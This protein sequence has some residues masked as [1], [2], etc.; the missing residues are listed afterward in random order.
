M[1]RR[2]GCASDSCSCQIQAGDGIAVGGAGSEKNPYVVSSTVAD[3]ETGF[4]V[5]YNNTDIIRGVHRIDFRGTAVS[6]VGG[7][8]EAV[9]TVTVP[10]PTTGAIIPTGAI[11]MFGTGNEPAGWLLCD[12][13]TVSIATYPNLFAAIGINFGGD[14]TSNFKLPLLVD[15]FPVGSGPTKPINST[16]GGS[17]SKAITAANLPPHNHTINHNHLSFNTGDSGSHDH[18][19]HSTDPT[20]GN[21]GSV[22]RGSSGGSN[23]KGPIQG[24]G[25][26]RHSIDVPTFSGNSGSGPGAAQLL[27]ITPPYQALAFMIKTLLPISD[28]LPRCF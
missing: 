9:V 13:R 25:S 11:W 6:V 4:D 18:A 14:G 22:T 12:G 24:D 10:D 20:G 28:T 3:I 23:T 2:C 5:Q 15:R 27:D 26:H 21:T 16:P 7:S 1:V 19:I 8:D 17:W